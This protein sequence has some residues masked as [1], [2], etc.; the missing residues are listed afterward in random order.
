MIKPDGVNRG[1]IGEVINKFEKK[2]FK[3]VAMKYC[4]P[5]KVL[6]EKHYNEHALKPFY[7]ELI[8]FMLEGPVVPMV[9]L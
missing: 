3:M 4:K 8:D 5:S 1:L 6:I 7:N 9:Q 2:G